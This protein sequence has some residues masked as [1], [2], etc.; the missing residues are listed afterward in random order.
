MSHSSSDGA[1]LSDAK[2]SRGSAAVRTLSASLA[3]FAGI[4]ALTDDAVGA[5]AVAVMGAPLI[6]A[7]GTDRPVS[8]RCAVFPDVSAVQATSRIAAVDARLVRTLQNCRG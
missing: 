6:G 5:G 7:A 3:K 4:S 1:A 8:A 2:A